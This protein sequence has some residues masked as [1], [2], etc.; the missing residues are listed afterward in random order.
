MR[1]RLL[2]TR[3]KKEKEVKSKGQETE[4]CRFNWSYFIGL[5]LFSQ[6]SN[7][8]AHKGNALFTVLW[9]QEM[10]A[11]LLFLLRAHMDTSN[12]HSFWP[13]DLNIVS[14]IS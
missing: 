12:F 10:N 2:I 14:R 7:E 5:A 4:L 11:S 1:E 3:G 13:Q 6:S 9:G 8:L